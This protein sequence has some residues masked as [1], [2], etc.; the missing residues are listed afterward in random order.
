MI[1][2]S[3]VSSVSVSVC[4]LLLRRPTGVALIGFSLFRSMARNSSIATTAVIVIV[5]AMTMTKTMSVSMSVS[6]AMV[7]IHAIAAI[8]RNRNPVA[9]IVVVSR[10]GVTIAFRHLDA[11]LLVPFPQKS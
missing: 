5:I 3:S 1:C 8:E 10:D 11:C 6:M 7:I 9:A 4:G 2:Y